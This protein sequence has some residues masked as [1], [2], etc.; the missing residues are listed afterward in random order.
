MMI[1]RK[2]YW[3][4]LSRLFDWFALNE[5]IV[6][7]ILILMLYIICETLNTNP[8]PFEWMDTTKCTGS[9]WTLID[10]ETNEWILA[11]WNWFFN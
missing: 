1:E 4:V 2:Y 6:T 9:S 8:H 7:E 10:L 11:Y 3:C 5:Y